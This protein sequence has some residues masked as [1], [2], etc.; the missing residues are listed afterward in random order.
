MGKYKDFSTSKGLCGIQ[1]FTK[2]ISVLIGL[3]GNYNYNAHF[4]DDET[5]NQK[6]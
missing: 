5:K 3:W 6:Y 4:T 1:W 2:H